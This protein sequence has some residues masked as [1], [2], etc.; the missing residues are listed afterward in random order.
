MGSNTWSPPLFY[1]GCFVLLW[2]LVIWITS[3]LNGWVRLCSIYRAPGAPSGVPVRLAGA[4]VGHRFSGY[5]R[6]VLTLW[7]N[8]QGVQLRVLFLFRFNTPDLFFAWSEITV[9]RGRHLFADY[10]ELRFQRAPDIPLRIY[11]PVAEQ[12]RAA[13]GP[14]WPED[15]A[16]S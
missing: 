3:H 8:E 9:G 5:Y 13:A 7:V 2:Y 11:G 6:N 4:R 14:H 16:R 1:A 10:V 15:I 12:V